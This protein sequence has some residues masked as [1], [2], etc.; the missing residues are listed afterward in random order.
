MESLKT[1]KSMRGA[2][3]NF[4]RSAG[5]KRTGSRSYE[6]IIL[7][8]DDQRFAK[9]PHLKPKNPPIASTKDLSANLNEYY[10]KG[11]I[12]FPSKKLKLSMYEKYKLQQKKIGEYMETFLMSLGLAWLMN[13]SAT[14]TF[15][16][17]MSTFDSRSTQQPWHSMIPFL[18]NCISV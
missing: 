10:P 8:H 12:E 6:K 5:L 11:Q 9:S 3:M 1:L 7:P 15:Q 14:M 2:E 16:A 4:T 18:L 13:T 17:S